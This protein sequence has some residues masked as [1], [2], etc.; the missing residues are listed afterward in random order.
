[1]VLIFPSASI[2]C[3][4]AS[5]MSL[6]VGYLTTLLGNWKEYKGWVVFDSIFTPSFM[7]I[8]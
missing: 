4:A 1:M 3:M 6:I 2:V 8:S 7:V 5:L